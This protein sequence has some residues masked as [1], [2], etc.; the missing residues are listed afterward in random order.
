MNNPAMIKRLT[1]QSSAPSLKLENGSRVAVMG[2]GP[3]GS[4]FK[5]L[6]FTMVERAGLKSMVSYHQPM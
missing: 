4:F 2:M 1:R 3:E 5:L 6:L